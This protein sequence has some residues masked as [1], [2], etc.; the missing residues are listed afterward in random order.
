MTEP[1]EVQALAELLRPFELPDGFG[2]R[3]V[4]FAG[5]ADEVAATL[6]ARGVR[7]TPS[8]A[9]VPEGLREALTAVIRNHSYHV[10]PGDDGYASVL[11][12]CGV[13]FGGRSDGWLNGAPVPP[14]Y[15]AHVV[16]EFYASSYAPMALAPAAQDRTEGLDVEAV[17]RL[18]HDARFGVFS[19]HDGTG[20][21][22]FVE[23]VVPCGYCARAAERFVYGVRETARM[24][25]E[26]SHAE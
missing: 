2:D 16:D 15:A 24:S 10:R 6:H 20:S 19:A 5:S 12:T 18:F 14:T 22:P 8:P 17:G 9:P 21:P 1:S 11:C 7:V 26:Q 25:E 13:L 3:A 23:P 4:I